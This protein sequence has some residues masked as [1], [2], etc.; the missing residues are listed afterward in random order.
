MSIL[1]Q[2]MSSLNLSFFIHTVNL[3]KSLR[4]VS[5]ST[6]QGLLEVSKIRK[7]WAVVKLC[8]QCVLTVLH[9]YMYREHSLRQRKFNHLLKCT[10]GD[11]DKDRLRALH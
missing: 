8:L 9:L 1:I 2:A 6:Q 7:H 5:M 11:R 10:L 3:R 4:R